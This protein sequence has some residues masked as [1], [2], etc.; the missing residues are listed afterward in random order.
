MLVFIIF[1]IWPF[2]TIERC[3]GRSTVITRAS[4]NVFFNSLQINTASASA[5]C[6]ILGG[7]DT[8]IPTFFR[9]VVCLSVVCHIRAPCLNRSTDLG[10]IWQVHR[11]G[12]TAH[13]VIGSGDVGS[14]SQP[15][16]AI[17]NCSQTYAASL[18]IQTRNCVDLLQWFRLLPNYFGPCDNCTWPL[19]LANARRTRVATRRPTSWC[20]Q[21]AVRC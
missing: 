7:T 5:C 21:C 17:A 10:T 18:R 8:P 3:I 11:K 12:P 20:C 13:C 15:K 19:R 4:V 9:R 6:L 1:T 2:S 14:N 16:H